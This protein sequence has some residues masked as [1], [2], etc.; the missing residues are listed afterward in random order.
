MYILIVSVSIFSVIFFNLL[1]DFSWTM[2]LN[3]LI[4]FAIVLL[5]SLFIA[6]IIRVLPSK[7][8]D[9]NLKIY[10]VSDKERKFLVKIGIKKW[11]DKIP[12]AGKLVNFK[13]DKIEK[14]NDVEYLNK[15]LKEMCYG[16]CLHICCIISSLIGMC[17]MPNGCFWNISFVI[18][19]I[20]SLLNVPSILIQRYNRPRFQAYVERLKKVSNPAPE[21]QQTQ[22]VK[23]C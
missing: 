1:A 9:P 13:K 18:A 4:G 16:E 2:A 20:Y 10:R 14:P 22:E 3:L 17:F 12:E 7:W 11:K 8:F 19:M 23:D 6:L 5:P 15:F 21:L